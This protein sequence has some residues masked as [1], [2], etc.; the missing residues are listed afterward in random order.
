MARQKFIVPGRHG[1]EK[2]ASDSD[3]V[4]KSL[5]ENQEFQWN[6]LLASRLMWAVKVLGM[7]RCYPE[8][9]DTFED[10]DWW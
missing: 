2:S 6:I 3:T 10:G 9:R 7:Q 1:A 4:K 8:I 5:K